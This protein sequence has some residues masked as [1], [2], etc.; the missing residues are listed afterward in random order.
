MLREMYR[1][2]I[3]YCKINKYSKMKKFVGKVT[4]EERDE[5]QKL[6]ERR[7]GLTELATILTPENETLYEKLVKDMGES[8]TKFHEWW[9]TMGQ[10]YQWESEEN[11]NW[12]IDFGTCEV[13]LVVE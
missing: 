8:S 2:S 7:N 12:E 9:K 5:I 13:Y 3:L 1:L 10:K 11:G 4:L 6:F